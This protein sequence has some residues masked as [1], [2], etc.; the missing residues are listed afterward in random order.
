MEPLENITD[1]KVG[2]ERKIMAYIASLPSKN[3]AE[4]RRA[5]KNFKL[6]KIQ[7]TQKPSI[8]KGL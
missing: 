6:G 3:R 7:G 5:Q 4:R 2:R 1:T 8:G